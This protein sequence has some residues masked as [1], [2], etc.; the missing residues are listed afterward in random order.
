MAFALLYDSIDVSWDS[1][2][3]EVEVQ[4]LRS[5]RAHHVS[6]LEEGRF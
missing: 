1:G 2:C 5:Y 4:V 6:L 3:M